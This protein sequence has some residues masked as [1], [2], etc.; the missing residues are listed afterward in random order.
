MGDQSSG[1]I[2]ERGGGNKSFSHAEGVGR[3]H[4]G[5]VLAWGTYVLAIFEGCAEIVSIPVN[6]GCKRFTLSQPWRAQT[7]LD[8]QFSHFVAPILSRLCMTGP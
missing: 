8:P 2:Q 1:A 6:E 3:P 5:V 7:V 4:F